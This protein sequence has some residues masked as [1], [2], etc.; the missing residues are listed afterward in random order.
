MTNYQ[1]GDLVL[2]AFPDSSGL[3]GKQRP[4]LVVAH[5]GDSDLVLARVTT[6]LYASAFDV[7]VNDWKTAGLMAPSVVRLHKL[8]TL[9]K[10]LVTRRMGTITS[11]DRMPITVVLQKLFGSW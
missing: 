9:E 10:R 5:T 2:V 6:H 8:A 7:V 11:A 3:T 4:A 1:T